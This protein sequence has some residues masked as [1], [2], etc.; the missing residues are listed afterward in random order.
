MWTA[1]PWA[2]RYGCQQARGPVHLF[3]GGGNITVERAGQA[4]EA[5]SMQ[6]AIQVGQAGGEVIADTRGGEI[7]VGSAEGV[8]AESASGPVHLTDAAG[9]L[10]LITAAIGSI[11]AD[12]LAGPDQPRSGF[13]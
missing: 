10:S 2:A 8:H 5:H 1:R 7:R 9:A 11:L 3:S 4:V 13:P 6:G 12:L